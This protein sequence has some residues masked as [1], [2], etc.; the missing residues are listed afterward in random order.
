[1]QQEVEE[2]KSRLAEE[3]KKQEK[4]RQERAKAL[5]EN[6]EVRELLESMRRDPVFYHRLMLNYQEY[7]S[8]QK[9]GDV[10]GATQET[11][12]DSSKAEEG[13]SLV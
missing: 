8:Q 6:P 11:I 12:R 5:E 13:K 1:M 9:K 3:N 10:T 7:K 4:E 2:L